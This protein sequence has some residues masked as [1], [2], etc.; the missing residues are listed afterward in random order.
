MGGPTAAPGYLDPNP[1]GH[2]AVGPLLP[3][4]TRNVPSALHPPDRQAE[5][6][7][8]DNIVVEEQ[9]LRRFFPTWSGC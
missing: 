2:F 4:D 1:K 7:N 8:T 3:P 9:A 6:K 5:Q